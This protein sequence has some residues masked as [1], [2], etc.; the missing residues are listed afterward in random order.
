[1]SQ[2]LRHF[3]PLTVRCDFNPERL[4]PRPNSTL[5]T[6]FA[7]YGDSPELSSIKDASS[8]Y[9]DNASLQEVPDICQVVQKD[10]T[11][12]PRVVSQLI[13]KPIGEVTRSYDLQEATGFNNLT[14]AAI[15]V[16]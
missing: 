2:V 5:R 9:S 12:N 16:R 4:L 11:T 14:H 7:L 10:T 1:M 15:Q 8:G 13:P 6:P 3:P